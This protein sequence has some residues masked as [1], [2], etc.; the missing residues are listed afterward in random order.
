MEDANASE[1]SSTNADMYIKISSCSSDSHDNHVISS[2]AS[3]DIESYAISSFR[4]SDYI[5]SDTTNILNYVLRRDN[6]SQGMKSNPSS[7]SKSA[8]TKPSKHN[9]WNSFK[10]H[11]SSSLNSFLIAEYSDGSDE[12]SSESSVKRDSHSSSSSSNSYTDASH[13]SDSY[14]MNVSKQ[15]SEWSSSLSSLIPYS[16]QNSK[17]SE[18]VDCNHSV[19]VE[20]INKE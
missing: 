4:S 7:E 18:E 16:K 17:S 6:R 10:E 19:A 2:S 9:S 1:K 15:M 13:H 12:S 3:S 11:L 5:N 20:V 14:L 8:G